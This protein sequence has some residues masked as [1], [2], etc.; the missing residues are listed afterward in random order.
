[1]ADQTYTDE[2]LKAYV[3]GLLDLQ[4]CDEIAVYLQANPERMA[5]VQAYTEEWTKQILAESEASF[6]YEEMM[7]E[8]RAQ[9]DAMRA[10]E[11]E[12]EAPVVPLDARKPDASRRFLWLA[13]ASVALILVVWAAFFRETAQPFDTQAQFAQLANPTQ[14]LA[15]GTMNQGPTR[16]QVEKWLKAGTYDSVVMTLAAPVQQL[17]T[18]QAR[19]STQASLDAY[20]YALGLKFGSSPRLAASRPWFSLV[21]H[22]GIPAHLRANAGLQVAH[23]YFQQGETARA[24]QLLADLLAGTDLPGSLRDSVEALQTHLEESAQH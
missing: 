16:N 17:D 15:K 10:Q 5:W 12:Q 8:A 11:K 2:Q 22:K 3:E 18:T 14:H 4:T 23:V 9:F 7:A 19:L 21:S 24:R 20:H 1:M 13:A 6:S